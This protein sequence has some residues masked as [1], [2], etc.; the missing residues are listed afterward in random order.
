MTSS[1]ID[2][3]KVKR[4][5]STPLMVCLMLMSLFLCYMLYEIIGILPWNLLDMQS[6]VHQRTGRAGRTHRAF[7]IICL[8]IIVTKL[9]KASIAR[10]TAN[11][12]HEVVFQTKLLC[13]QWWMSIHEFLS[14]SMIRRPFPAFGHRFQLLKVWSKVVLF[15]ILWMIECVLRQ[16]IDALD[17]REQLTHWNRLLDLPLSQTSGKWFCTQLSEMCGTVL[18]IVSSSISRSCALSNTYL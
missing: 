2:S 3:G 18:T 10:N 5:L 6:S 16:T 9:Y 7:V 12:I 1:W 13:A 11:T 4:S 17:S 8:V 15:C 14:Q